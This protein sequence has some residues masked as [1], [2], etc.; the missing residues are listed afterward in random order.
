MKLKILLLSSFLS[1]S[2]IGSS[3][4]D[5]EDAV[6]AY[7]ET[8]YEDAFNEF[9]SLAINGNADAQLRLGK[10]FLYGNA[11]EEKKGLVLKNDEYDLIN[12]YI[13]IE[14]AAKQGQTEALRELGNNYR[15]GRTVQ[16]DYLK[17]IEWYLKAAEQG[18]AESALAIGSLYKGV[19]GVPKDYKK[20]IYWYTK[21]AEVG[22]LGN[23][24]SALLGQIYYDG[25]E[26]PKD[27]EEA[28]KWWGLA[29]ENGHTWSL[30]KLIFNDFGEYMPE[31]DKFK[32]LLMSAEQEDYD[33]AQYRVGTAYYH[34][35][36]VLK[37]YNEAFKYFTLSA[38][39]GFA[40]SQVHLGY[41]YF[42]GQGTLKDLSKAS[43]WI[44]MGYS[45]PDADESDKELAENLWNKEELWK[46]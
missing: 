19:E 23:T 40:A 11:P 3:S 5:F 35:L 16:T 2:L 33:F 45:N 10:M 21:T 26:T 24:T 42:L 22:Y 15:W 25:K 36:G 14:K 39:Q 34:G 7:D 37:N 44:D 13:W 46:Y 1:I 9:E 41:L 18:D 38:N 6:K 28:I 27:Y 17:A 12:G 29:A 31:S 8:R 43:Y 30:N 20:V 32:W 4:A